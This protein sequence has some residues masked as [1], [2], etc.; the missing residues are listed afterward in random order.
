MVLCGGIRHKRRQPS[1]R[2]LTPAATWT[3]EDGSARSVVEVV[4][5]ELGPSLRWATATTTRTTRGPATSPG[6]TTARVAPSGAGPGGS[7]SVVATSYQVDDAQDHIDQRP[8]QEDDEEHDPL[9]GRPC[10]RPP[11]APPARQEDDGTAEPTSPLRMRRAFAI[12]TISLEEPCA[13]LLY[14]LMRPWR[15]WRAW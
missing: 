12:K 7:A 1:G 11:A 13:H 3:A 14:W 6:R 15:A 9:Q 10:G 8:Q 5:E 4:A 2:G